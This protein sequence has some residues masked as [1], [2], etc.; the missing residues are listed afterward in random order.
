[1]L[2]F[3]LT[4]APLMM[5]SQLF[6][7][8]IALTHNTGIFTLFTTVSVIVSYTIG[9]F[10]YH[11]PVNL[12]ALSGSV[13]IICGISMTILTKTPENSEKTLINVND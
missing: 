3:V 6:S 4:G 8:G 11:E 12:I 9:L 2:G 13:L 1:M 7:A 5:A 10:R